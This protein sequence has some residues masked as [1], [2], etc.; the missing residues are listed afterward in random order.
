MAVREENLDEAM[1]L[2]FS[3]ALATTTFSPSLLHAGT[4]PARTMEAATWVCRTE[5]SSGK[6]GRSRMWAAAALGVDSAE[7]LEIT[8]PQAEL[9]LVL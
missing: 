5:I 7:E 9:G 1:I 4:A 2:S 6:V 3:L 8:V